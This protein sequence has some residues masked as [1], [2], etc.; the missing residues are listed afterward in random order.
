VK[1]D[2]SPLDPQEVSKTEER[3]SKSEV[4]SVEDGYRNGWG[5]ARGPTGVGGMGKV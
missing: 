2:E 5:R 4:E 3:K 1:A